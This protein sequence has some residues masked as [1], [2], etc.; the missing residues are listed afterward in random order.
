[1]ATQESTLGGGRFSASGSTIIKNGASMYN[2][3]CV[4]GKDCLIATRNGSWDNA[5]TSDSFSRGERSSREPSV[6]V[7]CAQHT[8]GSLDG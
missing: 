2:D 5:H 8:V 6:L 1:M 4:L 3:M 7:Q